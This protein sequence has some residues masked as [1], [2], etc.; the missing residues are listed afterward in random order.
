MKQEDPWRSNEMT[1][2]Y[3]GQQAINAKSNR[4]SQSKEHYEAGCPDDGRGSRRHHLWPRFIYFFLVE[5]GIHFFSL[6]VINGIVWCNT[7]SHV[8]RF[9]KRLRCFAAVYCN[10]RVVL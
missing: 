2:P 7:L 9:H 3:P 4:Q 5:A 6:I 10:A 1:R 8:I